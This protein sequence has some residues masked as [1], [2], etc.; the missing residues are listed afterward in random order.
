M[1]TPNFDKSMQ[2]RKKRKANFTAAETTLLVDL[3]EK[4]LPTLRGKFSSTV[5]NIRKQKIWQDITSQLNSLGYEKRTAVEVREK[6]R[7]MTQNAKKISSGLKKSWRKTGGGPEAK[8]ADATTEKLINL[9]HDEPSFSGIQG[10]FDSG[11][12]S[13]SGKLVKCLKCVL[14][15]KFTAKMAIMAINIV[16]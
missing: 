15:F 13:C 7:N 14:L 3:V 16:L 5:T 8:P 6:W 1:A 10:G 11:E 2:E 4:N 9:F 12:P